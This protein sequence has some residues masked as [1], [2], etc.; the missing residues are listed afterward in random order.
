[1]LLERVFNIQTFTYSDKAYQLKILNEPNDE[2]FDNLEQLHGLL[3][4]IQARLSI[5][6]A[7][8][9]NIQINSAFRCPELNRVIGGS[10]TSDHCNGRAADTVAIGA[11]VQDYF[12]LVKEL[13]TDKIIEVDQVI[14]E[15]DRW[16]HV[17][18]R[19]G[20]NRNQFLKAVKENGKT[21]Y[22]QA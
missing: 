6:Y 21:I 20:S 9:I 17:S 4:H 19:K 10:E 22:K 1:M 14:N 15:F 8:P 11:T 13:V 18:F 12:N 16:L 7:K 5:K 2:Q 3:L